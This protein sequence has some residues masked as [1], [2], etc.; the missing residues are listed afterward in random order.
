[1]DNNY[2]STEPR[3]SYAHYAG[4]LVRTAGQGTVQLAQRVVKSLEFLIYPGARIIKK[5][6]D[7]DVDRPY[8]RDSVSGHDPTHP[9]HFPRYAKV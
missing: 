7:S 9:N 2:N 6:R 3:E 8:Q 4:R 1:M 5:R